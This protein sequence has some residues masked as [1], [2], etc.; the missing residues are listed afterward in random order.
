MIFVTHHPAYPRC[1]TKVKINLLYKKKK[2]KL[3]CL[4]ISCGIYF[5]KTLV[6]TTRTKCRDSLHSSYFVRYLLVLLVTG[7]L[8]RNVA[9]ENSMALLPPKLSSTFFW[10]KLPSLHDSTLHFLSPP[11][12]FSPLHI[13]TLSHLALVSHFCSPIHFCNL[14]CII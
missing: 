1:G 10:S 6:Y 7:V 3:S 9:L 12:Y 4:D 14:S 8:Q 2:K 13:S 5:N 11:C